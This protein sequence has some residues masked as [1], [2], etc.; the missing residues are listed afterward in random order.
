MISALF[1]RWSA[2]S[3]A[4]HTPRLRLVTITPEMLDAE[5]KGREAVANATG[6][7][8]P[9][10][11]PPDHWQSDVWAYI[12]AQFEVEPATLG[13]QRYMV[14][15]ERPPRLI[16]CLGGFP[17]AR[18]DVEIGYSVV[19]SAQRQGFGS[20]GAGALMEWLLQLPKVRSVS[21]QAYE[22]ALASL[23]VMQRCGMHFVGAGDH[24][25]TVRYRRGQRQP[26][27]AASPA[28]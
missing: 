4:I 1:G 13:W 7:K 28:S 18:G 23:K 21:A 14:S 15:A 27:D 6:V 10:D 26:G 17:G 16:G 22:T 5:S 20:E 19:N 2:Q 11:W 12:L 3:A 8:V 9:G 24:P 25:G